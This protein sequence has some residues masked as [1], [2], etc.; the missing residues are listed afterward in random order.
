MGRFSQ[1]LKEESGKEYYMKLH[2]FVE[3]Q[4][5]TKAIFPPK[6]NIFFAL[7]NTPYKSSTI[8]SKYI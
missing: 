6:E 7:E 8:T 5:K 2:T 4:Y 3:E 1:I